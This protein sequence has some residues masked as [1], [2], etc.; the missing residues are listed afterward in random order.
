MTAA[1]LELWGVAGLPEVA[2][3]DDLAMLLADREPRLRDGDI[4]VVTSKIVSK[5]EGRVV[6]GDRETAIDSESVRL[7]ARRGRTRIV[8]TR[9]GFVLAAAGVDGSNTEQGTIVLLP[10][11]P[12]LSA[13]RIRAGLRDRLRV[14]VGVI[15]SDTFGRPWREGLTD[16]AVGAA[17]VRAL[18]DYRGRRDPYGNPLEVTVTAAADELAGAADLAKGKLGGLPAAVV[19][20]LGDLVSEADGGGVRPL[21]RP[22]GDDMFRYGSG[23]VLLARHTVV[24]FSREPVHPAAVRRAVAAALTAPHVPDPRPWRFVL[25]ES[26]AARARLREA[27]GRAPDTAPTIVVA[28]VVDAGTGKARDTS[29]LAMG[30]AVENLLVALT[31]EGLGSAWLAAPSG[32]ADVIRRALDLPA[33]WEPLATIVVGHPLG[34]LDPQ[35]A[36]DPSGAI[37]TR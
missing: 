30:A 32:G 28:C 31:V 17:G 2:P 14:Q 24:E 5:A 18:Q 21:V 13:R 22:A 15:V 7:V 35:P 34:P 11:D 8:Q 36:P 16:V 26:A 20:G 37:V 10:L 27:T 29:L 19:R 9:H 6:H 25:V 12:D 23:D 4:L 1:R 33:E 3:G